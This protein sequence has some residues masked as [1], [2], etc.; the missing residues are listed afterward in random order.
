MPLRCQW[1][2]WGLSDAIKLD[3]LIWEGLLV[4]VRWVAAVLT[5]TAGRATRA[6]EA[7]RPA[8]FGAILAAAIANMKK[9]LRGGGFLMKQRDGKTQKEAC[10]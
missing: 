5:R 7:M 2:N 10:V 1:V 4:R 9:E 6:V 3:G 8:I